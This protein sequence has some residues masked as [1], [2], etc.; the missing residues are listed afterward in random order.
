MNSL[1][2]N[3]S[4][5]SPG[6]TPGSTGDGFGSSTDTTAPFIALVGSPNCGKTT[7]FNRLTGLSANVV[8]YPGATVDYMVGGIHS[9]WASHTVGGLKI[10]DTP[11]TYSLFPK[12]PEERVAVSVLFETPA[13]GKPK[14]VICV[15]DSTQLSRHLFLFR[16][17]KEAQ[18]PV[19]VALT[20]NDLAEKEGF[21]VDAAK[22]SETLGVPV[23][24]VDGRSG[25]G[26]PE[27]LAAAAKVPSDCAPSR[28]EPWTSSRQWQELQ[29]IARTSSD[30]CCRKTKPPGTGPRERTRFVDS[31]VLHPLGGMLLFALIMGGMFSSVF[32]MAAPLMETI[33]VFF[34]DVARR[35]VDYAPTSLWADLLGNGLMVSI[36]AVMVFTPQIFILFIVISI[37]EDSGYLARA[38]SLVDKPLSKIGLNGRSFVPILSGYACAIPAM[39]AA[40]TIPGRKERF[41]TLLIIPLMSCSARLPVFALLLG[42]LFWE[43][44][45]WQPGL[46]L[47]GLY[48]LSLLVGALIAALVRRW[49]KIEEKSFFI[50]ELPVY[51]VPNWRAVLKT[52][53]QKTLDYVWEAGP[54]IFTLA[55]LLWAATTFP[56]YD[57]ADPAEKLEGSYAA[58][59]GHF[60]DPLMEPM[61]GDWRTGVALISAFAAREVFVSAL[62]VVFHVPEEDE[63]SGSLLGRMQQAKARDGS[64]LFTTASI[65]GLILFF[66]IALQCM[67]TVG[68]AKR[69]FGGWKYPI[70]QLVGFNVLAYV[71][72]VAA[73]QGL[74]AFGIN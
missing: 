1:T 44:P 8:N 60:I 52:S 7:L 49:L 9:D 42:F 64:P 14:A 45:A 38:A 73:V 19:V 4:C 58:K 50:L 12:S 62:A 28:L 31:I 30:V 13:L 36:G 17:L 29:G 47:A 43:K 26:I 21:A 40:R 55:V 10:V 53:Y 27:L 22:L 23:I 16:Q 59:A 61:G 25:K 5:H 63:A 32:W 67:A 34:D 65:V 3:S 74:H 66:M 35:I 18:F 70:Y 57:A 54:V 68:V 41:L 24:P 51:R 2:G 46:A 72:A 48:F 15:A 11:G 6:N 33:S 39:L 37:L 20:M 71:V 69:E 56:K